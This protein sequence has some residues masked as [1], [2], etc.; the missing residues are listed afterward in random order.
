MKYPLSKIQYEIQASIKAILGRTA[1]TYPYVEDVRSGRQSDP[2][3]YADIIVDFVSSVHQFRGTETSHAASIQELL[4]LWNH[5]YITQELRDSR[6]IQLE[7]AK[8]AA[9]LYFY[10]P[11]GIETPSKKLSDEA[12]HERT[13][14][15]EVEDFFKELTNE[16]GYERQSTD[17]LRA[18]LKS[19]YDS[20]ETLNAN[21]AAARKNIRNL[22]RDIGYSKM[23]LVDT[24]LGVTPCSQNDQ[25]FRGATRQ[26]TGRELYL[27]YSK[28][29]LDCYAKAR[30]S[31]LNEISEI[32]HIIQQRNIPSPTST[33]A[34]M[35]Y[36]APQ[37][38]NPDAADADARSGCNPS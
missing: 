10:N 30:T 22:E 13:F 18:E 25:A 33:S 24:L 19:L 32:R 1:P 2:K 8:L 7:L 38:R 27:S 34:A 36:P 4:A 9:K 26:I 29:C 31:M 17:S 23:R 37:R 20:I 35:Y 28:L 21:E 11:Y 3:E 15:Q 6:E 14:F 12:L 16:P 5:R